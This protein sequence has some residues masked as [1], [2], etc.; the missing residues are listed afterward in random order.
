MWGTFITTQHCPREVRGE[1]WGQRGKTFPFP[2]LS[3]F[4]IGATQGVEI[5]VSQLQ[6]R[7]QEGRCCTI[8]RSLNRGNQ[9]Q[10]HGAVPLQWNN[11]RTDLYSNGNF[12]WTLSTISEGVFEHKNCFTSQACVEQSPPG[13]FLQTTGWDDRLA[14][15]HVCSSKALS[16]IDKMIQIDCLPFRDIY[17]SIAR[18]VL[19]STMQKTKKYV[20]GVK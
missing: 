5:F 6:Q 1:R 20:A 10:N 11:K 4:Y 18:G 3:F 7:S 2:F 16:L 19:P 14:G 15:N 9:V 8:K 13:V 12:F 17:S